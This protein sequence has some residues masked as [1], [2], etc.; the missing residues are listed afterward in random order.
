MTVEQRLNQESMK[1]HGSRDEMQ[2][3]LEV[4][5]NVQM[6]DLKKWEQPQYEFM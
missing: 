2:E 5:L 3:A 1:Q 6:L 4:V